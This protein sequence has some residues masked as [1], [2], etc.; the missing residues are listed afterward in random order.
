MVSSYNQNQGGPLLDRETA[1]CPVEGETLRKGEYDLHVKTGKDWCQV[2]LQT[3]DWS[4]L[5]G[6]RAVSERSGGG[7]VKYKSL[8]P[9]TLSCS[10]PVART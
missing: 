9:P 10:P 8:R 6:Q 4:L 1:F 2:S 7:A 5:A 3:G